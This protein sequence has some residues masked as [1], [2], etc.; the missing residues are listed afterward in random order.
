[1][2][3]ALVDGKTLPRDALV[4]GPGR[5]L[6]HLGGAIPHPEREVDVRRHVEGVRGRRRNLRVGL[7][8]AQTQWRVSG[9]VIGVDQVVHGP[10][11]LRIRPCDVLDDGRRA[12]VGD[13][14][15]AAVAGTEQR[16]RVEGLHLEVV[17]VLVV[18]PAHLGRVAGVARQLVPL[19]EERVNR[20]Q[21]V[22]L[23]VAG[24]L[25]EP[26]F[27]RGPQPAQRLAGALGRRLRPQRVVVGHRLAPI[28]HREVWRRL[29]GLDERILRVLVLEGVEEEHAANE[30]LLGG[31]GLRGRKLNS[32]ERLLP[33]IGQG[34]CGHG[35]SEGQR[36]DGDRAEHGRG[37]PPAV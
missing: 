35:Q 37:P 18:H 17:R 34:N 16:Q 23:L 2:E 4:G 30:R 12:H 13:D 26:L 10:G 5:A 3:P 1:M 27:A 14:V 19:A 36:S 32:P 15:A 21:P 20:P 6:V 29:L 9:V 28:R 7:G 22:P 24:R 33:R 25:R 8:V 11:V 31:A